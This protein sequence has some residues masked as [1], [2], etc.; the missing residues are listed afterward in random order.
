[1][2]E[3]KV[4]RDWHREHRMPI[5]ATMEQRVEWHVEHGKCCG[6]RPIPAK[7]AEEMEKMGRSMDSESLK[8]G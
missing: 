5:N 3:S 4:N 6:C 7:V 2:K 1:M 8:K